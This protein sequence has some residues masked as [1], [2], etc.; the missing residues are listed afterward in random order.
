MADEHFDVLVVGAGVSGIAAGYH[1]QKRCPDRSYAILEAREAMGGTWDLFRYPG[2]R[3]DSD[4]YTFGYAFRPWTSGKTFADGPAIKNYVEE[5][6]EDYGITPHIRYQHTVL[7]ADWDSETALWTVTVQRGAAG[8]RAVYTCNFLMMASGYYRYD[9]GYLPEFEG[10]ADFTGEIVHPQHWPEDLDYAG[11]RVA[12]IGSGATA[13][14]LV[15][16]MAQTARHVTMVQ[17]SPSYVAARPQNDR[18][19]NGLRKL[20][21]K[22]LAYK[23][24]RAKNVLLSIFF[25]QLSQ[26]HPE[27]VKGQVKKAIRA[28]LGD[29][30][31]VETHFNPRY[32]PW[33]QRFC[34]A[35]DGDF[36]AALKSGEATIVTD[37]IDRFTADGL[38]LQSGETVEADII[39][40]ATGL[41]MLL[42]GGVEFSVDGAPF[43]PPESFAYRGMMLSGMP[44]MALA[45]GYTNAS[46]TL[47][48]DLTCERMCRLLNHMKAK[49]YDYCVP[50]PP[51]D[52]QAQPLLDF[53]SGYVQRSIAGFPKQGTAAPWRTYQNYIQDMIAIRYGKL[54]DGDMRFG[55]AGERAVRAGAET[56]A[57]E[58][59][60]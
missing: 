47:K 7:S 30:F 41:N 33:D 14:T 37:H 46:W 44:N 56:A 15:P 9:E 12:I 13:V 25:Y 36:F 39:I 59:A 49:G 17:R 35:P 31:D 16:A 11:K 42:M 8:E 23:L 26:R 51:D 3:S 5:T 4:M 34:L 38:R 29:D 45:F 19:A 22:G 2:I 52:L 6:A 53:S 18:I 27:H 28:E 57:R 60:E 32:N 1:L 48:V 10:M 40:P 54:E 24:A 50:E 43:I 21:T 20:L 55:R 58:A